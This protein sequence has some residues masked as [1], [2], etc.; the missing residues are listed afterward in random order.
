MSKPDLIR[1][2][3]VLLKSGERNI[4]A[5]YTSTFLALQFCVMVHTLWLFIIDVYNI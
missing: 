5:E 4:N 3:G 2:S 1:L